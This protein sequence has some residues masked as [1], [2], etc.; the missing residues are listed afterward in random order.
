MVDV[1]R[2]VME[3]KRRTLKPE[4]LMEFL[5]RLRAWQNALAERG[6]LPRAQWMRWLVGSNDLPCGTML[7]NNSGSYPRWFGDLCQ[8]DGP[9]RPAA[10]KNQGTHGAPSIHQPEC[11]NP[12]LHLT[13]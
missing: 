8:S 11:L 10:T 3:H 13:S 4:L 2:D 9:V 7:Y 5:R 12:L 6:K 1:L